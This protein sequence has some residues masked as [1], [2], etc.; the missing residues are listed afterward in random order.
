MDL[1][2]PQISYLPKVSLVDLSSNFLKNSHSQGLTLCDLTHRR[3]TEKPISMTFVKAISSN[4]L[5]LQLPEA[6]M[7]M[8]QTEDWTNILKGKSVEYDVYGDFEILQHIPL[9]LESHMDCRSVPAHKRLKEAL[10][11]YFCLTLS[12]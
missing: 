11:S 3:F 4:C 10:I 9:E 7:T 5:S 12:F 8:N 2:L 1:E 6:V